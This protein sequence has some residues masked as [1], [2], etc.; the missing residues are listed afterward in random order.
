V[1]G[2]NCSNNRGSGISTASN[3]TV[4]T[5]NICR[6]NNTTPNN[7]RSAGIGV[8]GAKNVLISENFTGNSAGSA[9]P[10]NSGIVFGR[11][12]TGA[13]PTDATV[14]GNDLRGNATAAVAAFDGGIN[15]VSL[16]TG[17][18]F[19]HNR[20]WGWDDS[21]QKHSSSYA[22]TSSDHAATLTNTGATGPVTFTLPTPE[23]GLTYTFVVY[24]GQL[25][26]ITASSGTICIN[27]AFR[28]S[29]Q[30][31]TNGSSITLK[32]VSTNRWNTIAHEGTW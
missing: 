11:D 27:N 5:G 18:R 29:V 25:L 20:G 4:I 3:G 26:T 32:A 2:N 7:V 8:V 16:S 31:S 30:N 22:V 17:H 21:I 24:P 13:D 19:A 9:T 10:Q 12:A 28:T 23:E 1:E 15:P 6:D 14:V